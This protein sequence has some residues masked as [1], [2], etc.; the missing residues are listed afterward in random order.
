MSNVLNST[1]DQRERFGKL[2]LLRGIEHV[3][4]DSAGPGDIVAVPKL[5]GTH[6]GDVL[7]AGKKRPRT[8]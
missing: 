1:R 6:T 3:E 5:K 4:V 2:Q 7:C 8:A